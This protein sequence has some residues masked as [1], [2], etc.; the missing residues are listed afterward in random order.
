M[1]LL[2]SE[3][4]WYLQNRSKSLDSWQLDTLHL[5]DRAYLSP[6]QELIASE[7]ND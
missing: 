6:E 7:K 3:I 4:G 1:P 2:E 5:L